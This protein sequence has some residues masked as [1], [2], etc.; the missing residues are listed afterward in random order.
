M[1]EKLPVQFRLDSQG[2]FDEVFLAS[3][4]VHIE[5]M[6]DTGFWIGI[7]LP[8]GNRVS[9]NTGVDRGTWFFNVDEDGLID[10]QNFSVQRPRRSKAVQRLKPK[11]EARPDG[12]VKGL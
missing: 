7:D 9:V 2:E 11:E 6:N 4:S 12:P 1:S 5:R 8:D 10:G 3:A